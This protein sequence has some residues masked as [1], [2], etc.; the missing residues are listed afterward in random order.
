M[1]FEE[2]K[3]WL[4]N[5]LSE[6]KYFH[7]LGVE[8]TARELAIM[9]NADEEK[10]SLGGLVHDMAKSITT[11]ELLKIIDENNIS[12]SEEERKSLKTLHSPVGAFMA[13]EI[14]KITDE[15]VL[16]SIRFHTIGRINMSDVE[17]IVFL[18]DK[19]EPNTRP[20]DFREK[21]LQAIKE[22]NSLD[23][24]IL[25]CYGA[26]IKSLVDR[27]LYINKQT[28]DVWNFFIG[29]MY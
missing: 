7:V 12:V 17:K 29:L 15:D 11:S 9:F 4:K 19:I 26:T 18:A 3:L 1:Q 22:K 6:E 20:L 2:M 27:K 5:N 14:F 21:V 28:I 13:K 25:I 16:N 24:G 8:Q 23:A 10:A